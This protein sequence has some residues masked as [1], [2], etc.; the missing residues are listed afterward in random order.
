MSDYANKTLFLGTLQRINQWLDR[1][2]KTPKLCRLVGTLLIVIYQSISEKERHFYQ[3]YK[4][5]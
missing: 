1:Q 4:I 3:G 2:K 5:N